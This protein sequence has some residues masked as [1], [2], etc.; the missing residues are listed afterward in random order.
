VF[1][2]FLDETP[3]YELYPGTVE[4]SASCTLKKLLYTYFDPALPYTREFLSTYGWNTLT[5]GSIY[6]PRALGGIEADRD[7]GMGKLLYATMQYIGHWNP[8]NIKIE[9]LPK[10]LV[11]RMANMMRL[12]EEDNKEARVELETLIRRFVGSGEYG[13]SGGSDVDVSGYEGEVAEVV[14]QVGKAMGASAKL[15]LSAFMTGIVESGMTNPTVATDHD[16]LGWRQERVSLPGY[17]DATNVNNSAK[18]YF[19]EGQNIESGKSPGKA[20]TGMYQSTWTPGRLAQAIQGSAFPDRYDEVRAKAQALLE[21]TADRVDKKDKRDDDPD[22]SDDASQE[23]PFDNP[24]TPVTIPAT[25]RDNRP[26]KQTGADADNRKKLSASID[27]HGARE[28][29]QVILNLALSY[30]LHLTAGKNDHGQFTSSGNQSDHYIGLALDLSNGSAPTKEMDAF[31]EFVLKNM[32]PMIKQLIW[33]NKDQING[34]D[35]G[36]HMNHVHLAIKEEYADNKEA[37]LTA[38]VD[39][40]AGRPIGDISA[41]DSSTPSNTDGIM[42]GVNARILAS[43]LQWAGL[44][45]QVLATSLQGNKSLMNDKPLMPFIQQ[46]S[47]ASLRQFM[48]MPNGDFFAFYPDYFGETWHRPPYWLVDD[49]EVLE[50][51]VKLNDAALVTHEYAIGD[52]TFIGA[53]TFPNKLFSMGAISLLNAFQSDLVSTQANATR[54]DKKEDKATTKLYH[55]FNRILK[56]DEAVQFLERYGARPD[57]QEAPFVRNPFYELFMAYQRFMQAWSRQFI[58][59]FKLTFMPELYPGG[60]VGFPEHGLQ[61]Y[62]EE[63]THSWDYGSGF[64]TEAELSAPSAMLDNKG[65]P[66]NDNLPMNMPTAL[67]EASLK[68][69]PGESE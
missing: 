59:P 33:R 58:S 50:G 31:N 63:V 17:A 60:K 13:D 24:L 4:F 53:G 34:Y 65:K 22:A 20:G 6:N 57:V 7:G 19:E 68:A 36:G 44:E 12:F 51:R 15:K 11:D 52:T 62:I 43:N 41:D 25:R 67:L 49:I 35:I 27:V 48:S 2:G 66:I 39:A 30:G 16:S 46:M 5:D 28:G 54:D 10:D 21:K 47:E 32:K 56:Q 55:A 69:P 9:A 23:N 18:R 1:T 14:Y 45:E 29:M 64:V 3:Y 37:C 8:K 40:L 26:D 38:V 42:P 61:M